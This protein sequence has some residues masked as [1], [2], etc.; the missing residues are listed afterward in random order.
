MARKQINQETLFNT[1]T[2]KEEEEEEEETV[3]RQTPVSQK[4]QPEALRQEV[5]N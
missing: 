5:V 1:E 2:R 3:E 4:H